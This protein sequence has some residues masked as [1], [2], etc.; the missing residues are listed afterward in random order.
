MSYNFRIRNFIDERTYHNTAILIYLKAAREITGLD[1]RIGNSLNQGYF[2]YANRTISSTEI[3]R[4][5]NRMEQIIAR[6][7]PI[8][9]EEDTT[10]HAMAKWESLGCSEKARLLKYRDPDE[11]VIIDEIE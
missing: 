6:D 4:I 5:W 10:A 8:I 2:S 11:P 7:I 9:Q 1:M 3:H